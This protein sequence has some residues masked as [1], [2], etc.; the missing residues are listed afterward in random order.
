MG[1]ERELARG[2]VAGADFSYIN[3]IHVARQ[4]DINLSAPTVDGTG[5]PVFRGTRPYAPDFYIMQATESSARSLYRGLTTTFSVRRPRFVLDAYY[6]LSWKHSDDDSEQGY[7]E[8][9]YDNVYDLSREYGY[10]LTDQRHQFLA[11]WLYNL[12]AHFDAAV[13]TRL[14]SARPFEVMAMYDENRDDQLNDRPIVDGQLL[15]RNAFRNRAF[16]DVSLRLQR[17]FGRLTAS[18]EFFNLLGFDNVQIGHANMMYG[19]GMM[20]K[21]GQAMVEPAPANFNQLRDSSG[22]YLRSN[23]PGDPFQVQLGLRFQF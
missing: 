12:P 6:T 19:P 5:R 7:S 11:S 21:S 16:Y 15:A 17:H 1:L 10:S 2:V 9:V 3:T 23:I 13:V 14:T 4:R 8:I 18:A 20:M 22:R